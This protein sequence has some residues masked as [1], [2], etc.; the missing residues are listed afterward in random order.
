[1]RWFG[2]HALGLGAV[3]LVAA[4]QSDTSELPENADAAA[5]QPPDAGQEPAGCRTPA[6]FTT[7]RSVDDVVAWLNALPRPVTL[8]CFLESLPAALQIQATQSIVSAQPAVGA[9]SPRMFIVMDPLIASVVP[10]G[11]G[12]RLLELGE[13]RGDAQ[14]LKAELEFPIEH[15]LNAL[16]PYERLRFNDEASTCDFCHA[17]S[18]PAP[19][20]NY[21][22]AQISD[23]LRPRPSERIALVRVLEQVR[24]CDAAQEPDRCALLRALFD[25]SPVP[26]EAEFPPGYDT[27]F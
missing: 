27:F 14:S 6:G 1:M 26:V 21:P 17:N 11:D 12:A 25:R 3:L 9:R 15:E 23:A 5:P 18:E 8:P 4:C 10:A 24:T 19:G 13:R 22:F 2:L 7:P 16:S 20:L